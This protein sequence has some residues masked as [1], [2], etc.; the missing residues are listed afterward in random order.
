[1][2]EDIVMSPSIATKVG[3]E[4]IHCMLYYIP[5]GSYYNLFFKVTY[6]LDISITSKKILQ[7]NI[8]WWVSLGINVSDQFN[9]VNLA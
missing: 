2:L 5:F 4:N 3:T 1:M 8:S 6:F 7:T 9:T